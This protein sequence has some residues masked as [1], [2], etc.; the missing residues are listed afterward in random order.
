LKISEGQQR[1]GKKRE[2]NQQG[3]AI[4]SRYVQRWIYSEAV[5]RGNPV[6]IENPGLGGM[7]EIAF[8]KEE[9][10]KYQTG[11]PNR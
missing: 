10:Q 7:K 5:C 6:S 9:K 1:L 2:K 3:A 8:P 4:G 11:L